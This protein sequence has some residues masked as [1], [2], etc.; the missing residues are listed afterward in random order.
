MFEFIIQLQQC[1][2]I[3]EELT[4]MQEAIDKMLE[5]GTTFLGWVYGDNP[6]CI[7]VHW[8][9]MN[10]HGDAYIYCW[11]RSDEQIFL[12]SGLAT[13]QQLVPMLDLEY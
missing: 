9:K 3:Q 7:T 10:V 12:T 6:Y 4:Y 13:W 1:K 2:V 11:V 8:K 5:K